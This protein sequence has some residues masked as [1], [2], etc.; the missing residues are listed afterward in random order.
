MKLLNN[1]RLIFKSVLDLIPAVLVAIIV[2]LIAAYGMNSLN[3]NF[4]EINEIQ[5][6]ITSKLE[7]AKQHLGA[8]K[9]AAT[10]DIL[11]ATK[12]NSLEL[13]ESAKETVKLKQVKFQ[14]EF[15]SIF[16]II[17][18]DT[19]Y[20]NFVD[21]SGSYDNNTIPDNHIHNKL[22]LDELINT[23]SILDDKLYSQLNGVFDNAERVIQT[24]NNTKR[25]REIL[26]EEY[27]YINNILIKAIRSSFNTTESFELRED[28]D[29]RNFVF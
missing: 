29:M 10:N 2:A 15:S 27:F 26:D 11:L 9:S 22:I 6:E 25:I 14:S 8:L 12:Q 28:A 5:S 16:S 13:L 17:L 18:N 3:K 21:S 19:D 7:R 4:K 20:S 23:R 1:T 24:E